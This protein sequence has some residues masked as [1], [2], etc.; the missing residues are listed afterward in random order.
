M[1]QSFERKLFPYTIATFGFMVF[2]FGFL[3]VQTASAGY[4]DYDDVVVIVNDASAT[5]TAIGTYFQV[6]RSIPDIQMIHISTPEM[7]TVT[8]AVF[9]SD[10]RSPVENYL[11]ANN[12]ASTTNYIVTTKGV[13][14]RV[15]GTDGQTGTKASVDQELMLILGSNASFIGGGGSPMNAYKDKNERFSSVAYGYYLVTRLTG[16][17]IQDVENLID[18]SDVATTTNAGIFVL[19]VSPNHDI[20]GYQQVNDWMRA[21]APILTAKGYSVTLDET[22]TYLTGQTNVLGY[23]SWGSNDCCDTN[24]AIPGNTWVNGAIGETAVSF[25]GRSFTTGTSY[26]QSLVAD[27]IAEGITGISGYVYEPFIMALAHADT[28]FDRYTDG[29]NLADSYSMANFNLSWQ[30][31]VVGDPKTIIVKKPLPFSLSSPSDNTISLSASP[32]LTWG[33]SVSYNT[34]STYQLFIDGALNKDNV[35]AT[36]TTPSADLPSGTHTWHIEALDTLGNT[37]TSTETYTI[38]IIPEYSAGSHVFYVD[39]VLGDDANPGTQAAPYATIGKA[40]G[41]AQAGDTVMIIKNNNE[42]Y[43][44]MVTPAN[45]GTSGAYITFQG[46]SPSS[47]PEIWGSADVSDGWSSYDGGNSDTYQKSVVTNPV[48]VAAGASIGNLAKKVNGVSQDS[49]NAGE[50]YWTG[51][52]LYYR[53]AGGE[54][55]ATLHMEAGTRSY[56]IKGSDKSYIR[57][58]NLFVKYANVQGI[59]AASNSLVQ[60]IEVESCQSGIYLSDTNSKIYYSVARHNNIY[61]IHIGILSNGNQIY[62]SVAYGNGDSGIYVF[63]SGTN[64][65]L[66]NTVSAGNGSYAFSF[67]LVSPLSGFTADHNNWD[68]NSDET[69]PTYQGTNNQENIAPLFRDALGGD[70]R[71]EQFSPNIDTGADVGLITDILG[72]P[73][74]GTPDIGAYEYQPPYTIGTHA[75]SADGSLRIYADGKYRYTAATSTASVADFTVTPV[76]GFGAGDYAE[77]LN[78]FITDWQTSG[79]YAKAWTESSSYATTTAHIIGGLKASTYYMVT[80][81]G[82]DYVSAQT[83]ANGYLTFNYTGGYSS[84]TFGIGEDT[85]ASSATVAG[86]PDN[87]TVP[88]SGDITFSWN[89]PS[90]SPDVASYGLFIDGSPYGDSVA[91]TTTSLAVNADNFNCGSHSWYVR[92]TDTAGNAAH[93]SPRTVSRICGGGA[94]SGSVSLPMIVASSSVSSSLSGNALAHVDDVITLPSATTTLANEVE[95]PSLRLPILISTYQFTTT[96]RLGDHGDGVIALQQILRQQGFFLYPEGEITGY[97]GVLTMRAVRRFQCARNIICSGTEAATGYGVFGPMTRNALN[98]LIHASA[99]TTPDDELIISLQKQIEELRKQLVSLL[100][101]MVTEM[102]KVLQN[103]QKTL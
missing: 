43:R 83:D 60:N 80:I 7:E 14:L 63:L 61:G 49:L 15:N 90:G 32:T 45:S 46:V 47:K 97:Y 52:N 25:G 44:E 33:D 55:I 77:Y 27:W 38:N 59:F 94:P 62:N 102:R 92:T 82:S 70:F 72:N 95:E 81:D 67:Y 75:P 84:H 9:E 100:E 91:S 86:P 89:A 20:S 93:S 56:G 71:F 29:Y 41:I 35:A 22:N 74:Y 73:I 68:A 8:R 2:F 36:S 64:A 51:G 31:V 12:L 69:W 23:Y 5:S 96:L 87:Y 1:K 18:R 101:L 11:Q 26:G 78:V 34:I 50:W 53:L 28:L 88:Q 57:Y 54:N 6:A 37:A 39:N 30:Q 66:K 16:Y 13:P 17:T 24:N 79:T 10:I 4:F 99:S 103:G 3:Y 76:G 19:D 40:A 98:A 42:P 65:S 58:Q 21:A 85:N 48:I